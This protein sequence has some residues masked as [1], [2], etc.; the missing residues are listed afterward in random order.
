[1][2]G[3]DSWSGLCGVGVSGW[4]DDGGLRD[5]RAINQLLETAVGD[6][7]AGLEAGCYDGVARIG[8]TRLYCRHD[9]LA[10]RL[11]AAAAAAA[12]A[13]ATSAAACGFSAASAASA[14]SVVS[15]ALT[16]V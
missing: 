3:T 5:G 8:N 10:D 12:G 2:G 16:T 1:M 6:D 7:I 13:T 9:S 11:I 14:A 15:A 4:N